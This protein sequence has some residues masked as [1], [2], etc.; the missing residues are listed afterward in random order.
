VYYQFMFVINNNKVKYHLDETYE[1]NMCPPPNNEKRNNVHSLFN[2]YHRQI[3]TQEKQK[4]TF[5]I[6]VILLII[7]F[8]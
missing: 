7:L 6:F 3:E 8:K 2:A 1:D 4:P 5:I